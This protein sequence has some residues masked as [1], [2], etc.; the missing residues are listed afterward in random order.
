MFSFIQQGD[1][2]NI[3]CDMFPWYN[4]DYGPVKVHVF[5]KIHV[6]HS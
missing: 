3:W 4:K 1:A 5:G 6:R 2:Y